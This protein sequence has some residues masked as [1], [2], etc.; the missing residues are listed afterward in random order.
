VTSVAHERR[1]APGRRERARRER[2]RRR[3]LAG[4][5]AWIVVVAVLLAGVVAVNVADLRLNLRLDGL[6]R[7]RAQLRADNA[8][9]SSQI[10]SARNTGRIVVQ[11]QQRAG[12]V[13]ADPATTRY[14]TLPR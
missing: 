6:D 14:L 5:V 13:P 11:A 9:L 3:I 8:G 4:G 1:V 7:Q 2:L 10:A 12:L